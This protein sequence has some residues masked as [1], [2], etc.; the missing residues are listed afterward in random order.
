MKR[1][2]RTNA[3][4]ATFDAARKQATNRALVLVSSQQNSGRSAGSITVSRA[5]NMNGQEIDDIRR[6]QSKSF[7]ECHGGSS[8]TSPALRECNPSRSDLTL[9]QSSI[10]K[11]DKSTCLW[12]TASSAC[13]TLNMHCVTHDI[14]DSLQCSA[15]DEEEARFRRLLELEYEIEAKDGI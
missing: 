4:A 8:D 10:Q 15:C 12:Q 13:T 7:P 1:Q 5:A 2:I 9:L 3:A 11:L 14:E 6:A